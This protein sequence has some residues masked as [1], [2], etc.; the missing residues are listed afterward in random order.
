MAQDSLGNALVGDAQ[1]FVTGSVKGVTSAVALP[2]AAAAAIAGTYRTTLSGDFFALSSFSPLAI[3][4]TACVLNGV[5]DSAANAI[6]KAGKEEFASG[7]STRAAARFAARAAALTAESGA[8]GASGGAAL[9]A[10]LNSQSSQIN[11]ATIFGLFTA[12]K[13]AVSAVVFGA[14]AAATH[15]LSYC[16]RPARADNTGV[17]VVEWADGSVVGEVAVVE[18]RNMGTASTVTPNPMARGGL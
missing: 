8:I 3:A 2:V 1:K 14:G 13:T 15:A 7:C 11:A 5:A 10:N 4:S 17:R 9:T 16:R 12:T 18:M 6:V